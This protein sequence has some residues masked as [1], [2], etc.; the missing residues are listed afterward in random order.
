MRDVAPAGGAAI[1]DIAGRQTAER[2][3]KLADRLVETIRGRIAKGLL[4]PG[5][6]LPTENGLCEEFGVSRT[7]VREAIARL[8]ADGLV[9]PRQGAGIFVNEQAT[10][11]VAAML[12]EI[13]SKVSMVLNVL[14]VR[15]AV[16]IESAALAALRRSAS[17]EAEI[18]EAFQA[19][20]AMLG[21]GEP[22]GATDFAFHRAI[23]SATN[24]PFYVEILDVLGRRTIPRDL[25]TSISA[26]L[27]Q[28]A[29]YQQRLQAEHLAIMTAISDGDADSA[30]DAMRR[31]LSASRRRYTSLLRDGGDLQ[32]LFGKRP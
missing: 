10:G 9:T 29:E 3:P 17:Q 1:E 12:S 27:L 26:Q 2:R 13:G 30:R 19:F 28:S 23:A 8:S 6:Q 32:M 21:K 7:V 24:N 31:H 22:T 20:E 4:K 18:F 11:S 14:E 25:V 5:T 15:M 16:E